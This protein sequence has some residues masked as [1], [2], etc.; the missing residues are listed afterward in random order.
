M[1]HSIAIVGM[2]CRL[3]GGVA[4]P[5]DLWRLLVEERCAITEIPDE[6]WPK[7]FYFS[8][9]ASEPGKSYTWR[10]GVIDDVDQFDPGFFGMSPREASQVDPQQ[11]LLLELTAEALDDAGVPRS[12][13]AGRNWSVFVGISSTDYSDFFRSD[14][15]SGDNSGPL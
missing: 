4:R 1:R 10:A 9:R 5:D 15:A 7:Q 12:K 3:P 13:I 14:P 11:R 6:R 8:P 2:S